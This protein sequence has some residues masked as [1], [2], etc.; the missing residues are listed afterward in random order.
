MGIYIK[1]WAMVNCWANWS[2]AWKKQDEMIRAKESGDKGHGWPY[3][4]GHKILVFLCLILMLM[5]KHP[6]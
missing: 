6:M 1:F 3:R 2:G 4:N 5:R